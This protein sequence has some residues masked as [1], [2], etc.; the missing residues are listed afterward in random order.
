MVIISVFKVILQILY[1]SVFFQVFFIQIE[2]KLFFSNPNRMFEW[3]MDFGVECS[4]QCTI[5]LLQSSSSPG[6]QR[7]MTLQGLMGICCSAG[8][9]GRGGGW[10]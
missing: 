9:G 1:K 2:K 6:F 5:N 4:Q 7:P 3:L 10:K 8:Y